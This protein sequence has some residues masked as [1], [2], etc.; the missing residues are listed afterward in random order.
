VYE[1][2]RARGRVTHTLSRGRLVW[3][4]DELQQAHCAPGSGRYVPMASFSPWL[5]SGLDARDAAAAAAS[6]ARRPVTAQPAGDA[7]AA[8]ARAAQHEEL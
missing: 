1:G 3:A 7:A 2:R 8:A 5:F 6:P 4:D